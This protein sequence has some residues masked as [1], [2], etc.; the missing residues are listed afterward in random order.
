MPTM[1]AQQ[2]MWRAVMSHGLVLR[3]ML[4]CAV[5]HWAAPNMH[6]E[7]PWAAPNMHEEQPWAAPNMHEEQPCVA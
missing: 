1:A 4:V 5:M 2:L 3:M 7:Q 6:E